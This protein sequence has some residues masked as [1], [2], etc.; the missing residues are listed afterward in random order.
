[1]AEAPG[2]VSHSILLFC[3]GIGLL[4][5]VS[6]MDRLVSILL[7]WYK[8]GKLSVMVLQRT[9]SNCSTEEVRR[10]SMMSMEEYDKPNMKRFSLSA[11]GD[12]MEGEN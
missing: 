10:S 1:M 6:V 11:K 2:K 7:S 8:E 4:T 9:T 12:E 3:Q 5:S